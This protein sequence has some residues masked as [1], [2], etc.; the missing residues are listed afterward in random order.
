MEMGSRMMNKIG[1]WTFVL[2]TCCATIH[3][4]EPTPFRF[5]RSTPEAQGVRSEAILDFI[6]TAD[7][8]L[9]DMNSFFTNIYLFL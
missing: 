1:C 2:W 5:P 6:E 4:A 8:E 9:P 7:R 3:S